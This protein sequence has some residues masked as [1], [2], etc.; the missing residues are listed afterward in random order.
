MADLVALG[1][2]QSKY[3]S[4]LYP[5]TQEIAAAAAFMGFDGIISPSARFDCEN[6]VLFLDSFNLKNIETVSE[7]AID[8]G[9]WRAKNRQQ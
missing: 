9:D 2:E 4:I 7:T 1:V 8:W 6:I 5:R 3:P